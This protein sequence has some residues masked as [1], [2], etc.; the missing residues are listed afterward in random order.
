[1][2]V[3]LAII[4]VTRNKTTYPAM[5]TLIKNATNKD[6]R[7]FS[8]EAHEI[9]HQIAHAYPTKSSKDKLLMCGDPNAF[10][11]GC[12]HGV[13]MGLADSHSVTELAGECNTIAKFKDIF[14]RDCAHGIGHILY[15]GNQKLEPTACQKLF[16][17][18]LFH[19]CISGVLME[20][21]LGTHMK[22][23]SGMQSQSTIKVLDCTT[24]DDS[25]LT[26]CAAATGF[27]SL[28]YVTGNPKQTAEEC[29]SFSTKLLAASCGQAALSRLIGADKST[30]QAFISNF[31]N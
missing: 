11:G 25:I 10:F 28:Y 3:T 27:Y 5:A 26:D 15:G 24:I 30:K 18:Q 22:I 1:M 19:D 6:P 23:M 31:H 29:N 12:L 9:G 21:M 16:T 20:A 17:G 14:G 7:L 13:V 8:D 2:I 4:L